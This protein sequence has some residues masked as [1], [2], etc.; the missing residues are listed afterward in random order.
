MALKRFLCTVKFEL[1]KE[2]L[3]PANAIQFMRKHHVSLNV[4]QQLKPAFS[5][6]E[7]A[8]HEANWAQRVDLAVAYR[9]LEK[10]GMHEGVCN[11]LTALA[12]STVREEPVMLL[13]PHG[14][15]WSEVTPSCFIGLDV[16]TGEVIEGSGLPELTA[17]VIHRAVYRQ[18]PDVMSVMH[19]HPTYATVMGL[20]KDQKLEMLHQNSTR[21]L[22]N[23]AYDDFYGAVS[24]DENA[25]CDR[26]ASILGDKE[27]LVMGHHGLLTVGSSIAMA[28]DL[29][30]YFEQAAKVQ[31]LAYQTGKEIR[32]MDKNVAE[33]NYRVIQELKH[34]YANAHLNALKNVFISRDSR[35]FY[36]ER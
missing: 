4:G 14:Y 29:H 12:P 6:S 22:H 15:Y 9:A 32:Q 7:E 11:H 13:V 26:I 25:E 18:R 1:K 31:I 28:F 19:T 30:Y 23:V 5:A 35:G 24:N 8:R 16:K 33:D 36:G 34:Q 10:Y 20:L 2:T 21:Y 3:Q 17:H 27:V